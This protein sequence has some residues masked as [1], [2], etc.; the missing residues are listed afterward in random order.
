MVCAVF[1][2]FILQVLCVAAVVNTLIGVWEHGWE[3]GWIDGASIMIAIVIITL[4][5]VGNDYAKEKQFQQLMSKS[6]ESS[7]AVR[8]NDAIVE[9][10]S[11]QLVV[12][13]ILIIS[14][15]KTIPADAIVLESDNLVCS[16]AALTG[17]PEGIRKEPLTASTIMDNPNPFLIQG[18]LVESGDGKALVVAVGNSTQQGRAGLSMNIEA[19]QT[20]L[21]K[22]LDTIANTIGKFGTYVAILTF[23]AIVIK[24][25]C[26]TFL[27]HEREFLSAQNL[28]DVLE[29][30]ILAV[31]VIVVAVPEGLPLAV[32]IS[33]A[34]SVNKMAQL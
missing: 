18:S 34:F 32:T 2:D 19:E 33:L 3:G 10:N 17:E 31:T 9:L 25:L 20:P 22:K 6:D 5:T 28:N 7:I 30:F 16:E 21:Q 15:G 4:V 12:G 27:A 11:E 14:E 26:L 1:E 29:G 24:A 23:I 13:D 8:R